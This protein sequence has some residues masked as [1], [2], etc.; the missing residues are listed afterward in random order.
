MTPRLARRRRG[1]PESCGGPSESLDPRQGDLLEHRGPSSKQREDGG[2]IREAEPQPHRR[3]NHWLLSHGPF[4]V[5][6]HDIRITADY[7]KETNERRKA[8]QPRLRQLEM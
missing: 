8:L 7:S 2:F 5:D 1:G 6:Q 3:G 4:R